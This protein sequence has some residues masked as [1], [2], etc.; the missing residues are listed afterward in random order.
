VTCC[1]DLE[2]QAHAFF[3]PVGQSY[4]TVGFVTI[5]QTCRHVWKLKQ[6]LLY[7]VF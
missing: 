5:A 1:P 3:R 7:L 4:W 6:T 2:L